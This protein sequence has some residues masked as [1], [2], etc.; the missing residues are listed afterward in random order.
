MQPTQSNSKVSRA[1]VLFS[2]ALLL[3]CPICGNGGIFRNW[4]KLKDRCPSCNYLFA[5]G[6]DGYRLARIA[7]PEGNE[8][9][10]YASL[11]R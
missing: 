4:F 10:I 6:E 9:N 1:I 7:D 5:R 8:L 2:R 3:H 11:P